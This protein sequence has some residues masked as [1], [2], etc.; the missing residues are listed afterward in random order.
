MTDITVMTATTRD[1]VGKG[2]A[3][4]ARRGGRVPAVIYGDRKPPV[5]ITVDSKDLV[6]HL[7]TGGFFNT[8]FEIGIDGMTTRV[9]P[10]DVQTHPVTDIP[11]HVDFLRV[12]AD[13]LVTVEVPVA[14]VNEEDCPGLRAGGVLNVVRY[15][16]EVS[17]RPDR[18]PATIDVDLGAAELGDSLHISAVNLPDGVTPAI[19]DRDFTIVTIAAPT[20]V[21]A[22]AAEAGAADEDQDE[23]DASAEDAASQG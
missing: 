3:R 22:E 6:Q 1:R 2:S 8:L 18:I 16:I 12:A 21:A 10:R 9:L 23:T 14:F 13:T 15:S 19:I 17:C 7:N 11:E 20:V 4:A 5:A